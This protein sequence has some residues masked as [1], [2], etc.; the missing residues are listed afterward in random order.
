MKRYYFRFYESHC[1][2]LERGYGSTMFYR[3]CAPLERKRGDVR[4]LT[5]PEKPSFAAPCGWSEDG[6]S[7]ER[8]HK[9]RAVLCP[10]VF[11]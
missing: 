7:R 9:I 4:V 6:W 10:S 11:G 8:E 1:T 3:H 2:P 5:T